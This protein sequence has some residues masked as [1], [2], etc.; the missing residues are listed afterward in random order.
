MVKKFSRALARYVFYVIRWTISHLPYPLFKLFAGFFVLLSRPLLSKKQ[1]IAMRNLKIAFGHEYPDEK[2]EEI[3]KKCYKTFSQGMIDLIYFIDRPQ[4]IDQKVTI[5]GKEHLDSVLSQGKGAIFVSAHFGNFILM[6]LRMVQA[7]YQT[8]VIMRRTRDE[9]WEGYISEFREKRGIKTI[10][11][12]PAR[13]CVQKCLR[14]LRNNEILFILLDQN[15]GGDGRVFVD[16]FGI[17]A[18]T[19][20]GPVIF[21]MRTQAPILPIFIMGDGARRCKILIEPPVAVDQMANDEET[22]IHNIQKITKII[23]KYIRERPYEWGGWMHNR[24]KSK[25]IEEQKVIDSVN[26]FN[27]QRI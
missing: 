24:W 27:S 8:N 26:Q 6:Y 5:E 19:A 2:I 16:F 7:G 21:S 23:E 9:K 12:L 3:Y 10:Y 25:T 1:K 11:D 15:Y 22:I 17:K 13:Q 4:Q 14:A 18:A 20:T